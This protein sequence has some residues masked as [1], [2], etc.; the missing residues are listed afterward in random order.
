MVK[1]P[2]KCTALEVHDAIEAA[3]KP[4]EDLA[5]FYRERHALM[6]AKDQKLKKDKGVPEGKG[7]SFL[8]GGELDGEDWVVC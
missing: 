8:E 5:T 3:K 2:V 6:I 4:Y 7:E 1:P